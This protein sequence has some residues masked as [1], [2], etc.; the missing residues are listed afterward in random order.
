MS[1]YKS[2]ELSTSIDDYIEDGTTCELDDKLNELFKLGM[3]ITDIN[4]EISEEKKSEA[5]KKMINKSIEENKNM[6]KKNKRVLN[7]VASL[8]LVGIIGIGTVQTGFAQEIYDR[9]EK[10]IS[11][12]YVTVEEK[13]VEEN[14]SKSEDLADKGLVSQEK[15]ADYNYV[16]INDLE[17]AKEHMKFELKV[18]SELPKGYEFKNVI[19]YVD[20]IE[21]ISGEYASLLFNNG[22]K[23]FLIME[24][25]AQEENR[26][27]TR[28][29]EIEE[30]NINGRRAVI[31]KKGNIDIEI[32]DVILSLLT[33][34]NISR[35]E[36]IEIIKS[37]K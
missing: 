17:K 22:E 37:I 31:D 14:M 27:K 10:I 29:S 12:R 6:N 30:I 7:R 24:I 33:K 16:F 5:Y 21:D 1:L 4:I 32:D 2:D 28:G 15:E 11:L 9:V 8:A 20:K 36:A 23:E 35:E 13:T 25:L 19:F 18:P 3:D 34:G 26:F